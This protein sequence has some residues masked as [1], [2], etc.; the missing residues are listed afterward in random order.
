[1]VYVRSGISTSVEFNNPFASKASLPT[2]VSFFLQDVKA[3]VTQ[4]KVAESI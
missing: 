2:I 3:S 4:K 1:M